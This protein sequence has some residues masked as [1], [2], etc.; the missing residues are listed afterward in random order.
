M[1]VRAREIIFYSPT[2]FVIVFVPRLPRPIY[3][4]LLVLL[5]ALRSG[6]QVDTGDRFAAK[7]RSRQV[8]RKCGASK[9]RGLSC[10]WAGCGGILFLCFSCA[11]TAEKRQELDRLRS[12]L[13]EDG[14][15]SHF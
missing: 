1:L 12:L 4:S 2:D 10:L 7:S 15:R 3:R 9:L 11:N 8:A 5:L 6:Q 14:T 13:D